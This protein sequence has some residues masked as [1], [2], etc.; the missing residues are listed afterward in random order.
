MAIP[1]TLIGGYLGSGKTTLINGLLASADAGRT[2]VVVND[3]GDVNIDA[4]LIA[5]TGADTMELTNGCICC[6]IT[7]DVR[8]TMSA[9]ASR[10]DIDHAVCEV[11]GIGDPAQ[12]G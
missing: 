6:Q 1:L 11:S 10:D 9:L 12:L 8:R 5:A 4:A 3:F 2:A 7:D